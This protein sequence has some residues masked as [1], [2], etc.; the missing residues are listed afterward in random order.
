M[1]SGGR[2]SLLGAACGAV[3]LFAIVTLAGGALVHVP[4]DA[5]H[6]VV[7]VVLLAFG[8]SWLR[9]A[10]LRTAGIK[11]WRDE[12]AIYIK[13][14]DEMQSSQRLKECRRV[15]ETA[16]SGLHEADVRLGARKSRNCEELETDEIETVVI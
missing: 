7:G 11:A 14:V 13:R 3:S 4:L 5:L 8:F 16:G 10:I 12:A 6:I 1:V 9:K 2:S 15:R